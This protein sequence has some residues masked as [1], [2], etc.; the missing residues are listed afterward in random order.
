MT[1]V[2]TIHVRMVNV[3]VISTALNASV[4]MDGTEKHVQVSTG[5]L[6]INGRRH[7]KRSLMA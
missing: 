1:I 7:A 3:R 4:I 5:N 6:Q 2:M